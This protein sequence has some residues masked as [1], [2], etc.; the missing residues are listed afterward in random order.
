MTDLRLLNGPRRPESSQKIARIASSRSAD[1]RHVLDTHGAR[2]SAATVAA[3]LTLPP[4]TCATCE[5]WI[6]LLERLDDA[7][8]DAVYAP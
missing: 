5:A 3:A 1:L 8:H 7:I 6:A 4:T 2:W